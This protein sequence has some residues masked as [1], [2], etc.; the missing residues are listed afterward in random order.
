MSRASGLNGQVRLK[1]RPT[2]ILERNTSRSVTG[3]TPRV[4]DGPPGNLPVRGDATV[5]PALTIDTGLM[6]ASTVRSLKKPL[7]PRYDAHGEAE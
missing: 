3:A 7:S 4:G 6:R 1:V 2:R 5:Q